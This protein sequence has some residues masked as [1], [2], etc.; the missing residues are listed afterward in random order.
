MMLD[1]FISATG[2]GGMLLAY[3]LAIILVI[4]FHRVYKQ[5]SA[6][7][8]NG[9]TPRYVAYKKLATI[10]AQL[11]LLVTISSLLV[12]VGAILLLSAQAIYP[13]V[14][15]FVGIAL[16]VVIA[17]C[18]LLPR[19]LFDFLSLL[20]I[21]RPAL[22]EFQG[23][24]LTEGEVI[25]F[26]LRGLLFGQV[27]NDRRYR[28]ILL[29][30]LSSF[31]LLEATGILFLLDFQYL[32]WVIPVLAVVLR[33]T[34]GLAKSLTFKWIA[35]TE[36]LERTVWAAL[37]PRIRQFAERLE[38]EIGDI[39]VHTVTRAGSPYSLTYGL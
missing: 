8:R 26:S 39:S 36:P 20:Y 18:M 22:T 14:F 7:V 32:L 24:S 31:L 1:L 38:V 16:C 11:S 5:Q 30:T 6:A 2:I 15:V 23:T 12:A 17:P 33:L 37:E 25:A 4:H 3:G 21:D 34:D 28:G 19:F 27:G 9:K 35:R 29:T 13:R 10:R